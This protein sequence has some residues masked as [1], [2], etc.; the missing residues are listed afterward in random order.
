MS[1]LGRLL[2]G[3]V[4]MIVAGCG[5]SSPP[6]E[7]GGTSVH[8]IDSGQALV[9]RQVYKRWS[10]PV[11]AT[12]YNRDFIEIYNR[13][14]QPASLNG[15]SLQAA[16]LR[17]G[18]AVLAALP[19]IALGPGQSYLVA[20]SQPFANG[21]PVTGD[22]LVSAL[23]L[24]PTA[25]KVAL[26]RGT[27]S[28]CPSNS[29]PCS[30]AGLATIVDLV[31][32]SDG[33]DSPIQYEGQPAPSM[34]TRSPPS[35]NIGKAIVR[36]QRGQQDTNNNA[37]D[38]ELGLA[39]PRNLSSCL[40]VTDDGDACTIDACD[41][42]SGVATHLAVTDALASV[43]IDATVP[44]TFATQVAPLH[45]GEKPSQG[46]LRWDAIAPNLVSV[47]RGQ[48]LSENGSAGVSCVRVSVVEQPEV[49][50]TLTDSDGNYAIA[51]NGGG[52]ATL[53]I[54]SAGSIPVDRTISSRLNE[55]IRVPP[56]RL[57]PFGTSTTVSSAA[58]GI[59]VASGA[60][61]VDADGA[62]RARLFFKPGTTAS[63]AGETSARTSFDVQVKEVTNRTTHQ[64][65]GMPA[66]LPK[67]SAFTYAVNLSIKGAE[68]RGVTFN[69]PVPFYVEDF[70]GMPTGEAVP[71]GYYDAAQRRWI[72]ADNGRVIRIKSISG[73][74]ADIDTDAD[75]NDV[76]DP[77]TE[78]GMDVAE[79]TQLAALYAPVPSGGKKLWRFTTNHFSTWDA[80]WG[81]GPPSDAD[82][83]KNPPP[84]AS[85]NEGKEPT[86]CG[87]VIG[88]QSQSLREHIKLAGTTSELWYSSLRQPEGQRATTIPLVGT[89]LPIGLKGIELE[90][91]VAGRQFKPSIALPTAA[92]LPLSYEFVWDWTDVAGRQL[93][94]A[95]EATVRIGYTYDGSYERTARFG[96]DGNGV[97][98]TA[99]QSRLQATLWQE[100]VVVLQRWEASQAGLGGW[101]LSEH[102]GFDA[103]SGILYRGNGETERPLVSTTTVAGIGTAGTGG[104]NVPAAQSPIN[105]TPESRLVV[106]R[107]GSLYFTEPSNHRVRRVS[108][109]GII[110]TFAGGADLAD[111][112][113]GDGGNATSARLSYPRGLGFM[114]DGTLYI[115][116]S[117]AIRAVD[118]AGKIST[119]LGSG[120]TLFS[121]PRTMTQ[122]YD[123]AEIKLGEYARDIAIAKDGS[124]YWVTIGSHVA[125]VQAGKIRNIYSETAYGDITLHPIQGVLV[126]TGGNSNCSRIEHL[127]KNE[128]WQV[129]QPYVSS[130]GA[131]WHSSDDGQL[132][133][134]VGVPFAVSPILDDDG[135]LYLA[136][137]FDGR[138]RRI[139]R[140]GV[141]DTVMRLPDGG[142][143]VSIAKG[144]DGVLYVLDRKN[145]RLI[146][147]QPGS[148]AVAS[149]FVVSADGA[150]LFQFDPQ[151]RHL[152]TFDWKT[153]L[154]KRV[155]SYTDAGLLAAMSDR[156]FS[157][158]NVRQLTVQ[159]D[160]QGAP[161]SITSP[162]GK[163]T[164]LTVSS[165]GL[166]S[167]VT[168]PDLGK[169]SFTYNG[170]L[171]ATYTAPESNRV[172]GPSYGFEF[173]G[174]RLSKDTDPLSNVQT[175][176]RSALPGSARNFRVTRKD[177][178]GNA[179]LV[180]TTY[181]DDGSIE[182]LTTDPGDL[183]SSFKR[184]VDGLRGYTAP[185]GK[186]YS[187]VRRQQDGTLTYA[188]SEA[189][190]TDGAVTKLIDTEITYPGSG[191]EPRE[192]TRVRSVSLA[193]A[194]DPRSVSASSDVVTIN[195]LPPYSEQYDAATRK[196]TR[197]SREGRK[198]FAVR[199]TYGRLTSWGLDGEAAVVVDWNAE[200]DQIRGYWRTDST[201]S[202][203]IYTDRNADGSISWLR[204]LQDG[205]SQ[206]ERS[207]VYDAFGRLAQVGDTFSTSSG[208]ATP[209]YLELA[210]D[211]DGNAVGVNRHSLEY[212]FFGSP[213]AHTLP[214]LQAGAAAA[215][216]TL[217]FNA[218]RTPSSDTAYDGTVTIERGYNALGQLSSV[219][220]ATGAIAY[221]YGVSTDA[222][223]GRIK[224]IKGPQGVDIE[225]G[226]V[227]SLPALQTWSGDVVGSYGSG[228]DA[229]FDL[230]KEVVNGKTGSVTVLRGYDND[231]LLKCV[232]LTSCV[233]PGVD[234]LQIVR[235]AQ[236]GR[237]KTVTLNKV[238]QNYSYNSFG[239]L[240]RHSVLGN[241]VPLLDLTYDASGGK[242]DALGRITRLTEKIGAAA[243][244]N[245]DYAY[246][247]AGALSTVKLDGAITE[248]Y[249]YD[250]WF[251]HNRTSATTSGG[252]FVATV[253]ARD[254]LTAYGPWTFEYSANGTTQ[255]RKVVA[256]G[257]LTTF[258]YD[259]LGNLRSV[260]LPN[261][262]VTYKSDGRGRRVSRKVNGVEKQWI[263]RDGLHPVAELD[264][265]GALV[266]V[267]VYG[268]RENVPDFLVRGG[269]TYRI[270]ADHLGSIRMVVNV[271]DPSD[272][273]FSARYSAFGE[274]TVSA[275]APASADFIPFGFAGGLYDADTGLVRFGARDYDPK[276]GRWLSRD[277]ILF[278]GG[279]GNLYAYVNSDPINR[280]DP[281]GLIVG[282]TPIEDTAE[283]KEK[284]SKETDACSGVSKQDG[285]G[286]PL[287]LG[288]SSEPDTTQQRIDECH[289]AQKD[290]A[291]QEEEYVEEE[292]SPFQP[293]FDLWDWLTDW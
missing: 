123:V 146:K 213:K 87:S 224:T 52:Q 139:N 160:S 272:V 124:K 129:P 144:P 133:V 148:T 227:G 215:K 154:L 248:S 183:T 20:K 270:I 257:E 186:T 240:S 1:V 167:S 62:R 14:S 158:A 42:D 176:A 214:T 86:Q 223:P 194:G 30:A 63:V 89:S 231:K 74:V 7:R 266:S 90:I 234:A 193:V 143:P 85:S 18:F 221:T 28:A 269:K 238:V 209:R 114:P 126:G 140:A 142:E 225:L 251:G 210:Y 88:C 264:A 36:K 258:N 278:R 166:L 171:L 182:I 38:F 83:P 17:L 37:N 44:T 103:R 91:N 195:G 285:R 239:E 55:T 22:L 246:D 212:T 229:E 147:N 54:E 288:A 292:S 5:D 25:G 13:S 128:M 265:N 152:R 201:T 262:T 121:P 169:H 177:Q 170:N 275:V 149:G 189:V 31:G 68:N 118:P 99:G 2:V 73:G 33:V 102:H 10:N 79:R 188:S 34:L 277:P 199:D 256:S 3:S 116:E 105:L 185:N 46:K 64:R 226:H 181:P 276:I 117:Q 293:L 67:A 47:A 53:R 97:K 200:T 115:V 192:V 43:P 41:F 168:G 232:S 76:D 242:R 163:V 184:R 61:E 136:M 106:G 237:I 45:S 254:V 216:A 211:R 58:S 21:K 247:Y 204:V 203:V 127:S 96:Y 141:I 120:T 230:S 205:V 29:W 156:E 175:L 172:S 284:K 84:R 132:A 98:I 135:A 244:K 235:Y 279:Q 66:S 274:A 243:A 107:D 119:V 281:S 197:T 150:E 26:V 271:A 187:S 174:G 180:D 219:T 51:F 71:V 113:Y 290:Y 263:Y 259:A 253:D 241:G 286:Q 81:W 27:A 151:G 6:E 161:L 56:S 69:K 111:P 291:D 134:D 50:A 207:H 60:S 198:T 130:N 23:R 280:S 252:T 48:V 273:P 72:A 35:Q 94:G 233:T 173:V 49:G 8:L 108:P 109:T 287:P 165:N 57:L 32:W 77:A 138:I 70:L 19:N 228:Y 260:V 157:E 217:G 92:Q 162:S 267:F 12:T 104:E 283:L 245:Y 9:I 40:G 190:Y 137:R 249:S 208:A 282:C 93:R 153:G 78:L 206:R 159:R 202:R 4:A 155:F 39:W 122:E 95:Q 255:S 196:V 59:T 222:S 218:D 250:L 164:S 179:H 145:Q 15:L 261:K 191:V 75:P 100:Q 289:Q 220:S 131:C 16:E 125:L 24:Y 112:P 11:N 80:N 101:S 82:P 268:T 65:D 236:T 110:S 178:R